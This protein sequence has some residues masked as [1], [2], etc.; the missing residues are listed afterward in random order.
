MCTEL[1][2]WRFSAS[3]V[4]FSICNRG[5]KMLHL[6][7]IRS[8]Y[9]N[10]RNKTQLTLINRMYNQLINVYISVCTMGTRGKKLYKNI[11]LM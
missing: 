1:E 3:Y 9:M 5:M 8:F 2:V 4:Y 10:N 11:N 7:L 6:I